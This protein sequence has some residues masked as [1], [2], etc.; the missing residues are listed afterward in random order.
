MKIQRIVAG[1]IVVILFALFPSQ[2][3]AQITSAAN[4][5]VPTEYAGADQDNIHVFCGTRGETRATLT[6]TSPTAEPSSFEWLRYNATS[7]GFDFFQNDAGGNPSSTISNLADGAYRVNVTGPS[8]V[9]TYTAWVFNN[10]IETTAEITNSDCNSFTLSGTTDSPVLTYTDLTNGQPKQLNK[11]TQ[12]SWTT[13]N[14]PVASVLQFTVFTPPTRDTDYTLT[15]SDRFGC[16]SLSVVQYVSIVTKAAIDFKITTQEGNPDGKNEAPLTVVFTSA[17]ENADLSTLEWFI[18]RD[19]D[20]IKRESQAN[21]DAE[22]DSIMETSY[23]ESFNYIFERPGSYMV[24]LVAQKKSEFTTCFDTVYLDDYIKIDTSFVEAPNFFS[25]GNDDGANVNETFVVRFFSMKTMKISIF[26][27]WGKLVHVWESDNV[28]GFGP[29]M[30]SDPQSV[31]DGKI[32][33]KLAT[34]GVYYYVAEGK[35]RDD[36]R[37]RANGFVHLFR[38]K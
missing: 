5:V 37:N 9:S 33:G 1:L 2:G 31:W 10:F 8:G 27:R 3:F 20:E 29:T 19:L 25:P 26:N 38:E 13:G 24:K 15:V 34:P 14:T 23:G 18:F 32:G 17:S 16:T 35:G 22:I 12:V 4:A 36:K 21:P 28:Q 6:A 7:G 30:A 11:E